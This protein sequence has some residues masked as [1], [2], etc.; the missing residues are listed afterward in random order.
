[1]KDNISEEEVRKFNK[2]A[3]EWWNPDGSF[4]ALHTLNPLRFNY[5]KN[6]TTLDNKK[7][8]DIGCGGGILT[9][10]LSKYADHVD[11]LDMADK[12]ILVA[13]DHRELMSIKNITYHNSNLENFAKVNHHQY[14]VLT[15]MEMLEHVPS[16]E[17][18]IESCSKAVKN[19][20]H[21]FLSTI[22]R[23]IKSYLMAIVGAEYILKLL[24][25]G[26]HEFDSFIKP[27]EI[28]KWSRK[29]GLNLIDLTGVMYNPITK[30]FKLTD[31]VSVN[32]MMYFRK[33]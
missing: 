1:M 23:N 3:Q 25:Q 5:I 14:D 8:L 11:G 2:L 6:W 7:C 26:T 16:P 22:N 29:S 12:A 28:E 21:L 20:G 15:C 17:Q 10:S 24:P 19:G 27:S 33:D 18:I 31:D 9:E 30:A 13:E 4:A 32:Y